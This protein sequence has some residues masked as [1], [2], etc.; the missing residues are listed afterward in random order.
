MAQMTTGQLYRVGLTCIAHHERCEME[1]LVV[2]SSNDEARDKL[3]WIYDFSGFNSYRV[4]WTVKEPGKCLVIKTKYTRTPD[5]E[6]D[7]NLLRPEGSAAVF[8]RTP[9]AAGKKYE[10]SAMTVCYAKSAAHATRKLAE[11]IAGGSDFV[12]HSC[13]ELAEASGFAVARDQS[14]FPR[15]SVVR[16]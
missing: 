14:V 9:I 10:V 6:P 8:Q 13:E 15:A 4:D 3:P 11:R 5:N 7:A 2:A 12:K 1:L 16:G